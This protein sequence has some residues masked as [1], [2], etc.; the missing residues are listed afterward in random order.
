[1]SDI[2]NRLE[3]WARW[4]RVRPHYAKCRSLEGKYK[5]PPTWHPPEP[6]IEV[7]T[8]DAVV[9]EKALVQPSFPKK[10]RE[11]IKY[12]YLYSGI[13][14]MKICRKLGIKNGDID[15]ELRTAIMML[16]N[17]LNIKENCA[18]KLL[19]AIKRESINEHNNLILSHM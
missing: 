2:Q 19:T 6:R 16:E 15:A 13:H 5:A 10:S 12:A 14:P 8:L 3:N 18:K 9:I 11:I 17:R 1:M 7:D 4:A